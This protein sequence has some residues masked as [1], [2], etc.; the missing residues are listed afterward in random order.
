MYRTEFVRRKEQRSRMTILTEQ[1]RL[2]HIQQHNT[3]TRGE[4][5]PGPDTCMRKLGHWGSEEKFRVLPPEAENHCAINR[6]R[7]R[8]RSP[9]RLHGAR[10]LHRPSSRSVGHG[11]LALAVRIWN[12]TYAGLILDI[13][14]CYGV[15]SHAYYYIKLSQPRGK[16]EGNSLSN[17]SHIAIFSQVLWIG[18]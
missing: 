8:V 5:L 6:P 9:Y 16:K 10:G 4:S 1:T 12:L 18:V 13:I 7:A 11:L 2:E 17:R 15:K 14:N 3:I